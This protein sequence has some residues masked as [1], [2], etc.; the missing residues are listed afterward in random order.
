MPSPIGHALGAY[1]ALLALK[2]DLLADRRKNSLAVGAAFVLGSLADADFFV[3]HFAQGIYYLRHHYFS[4][5]IPFA[6]GFTFLCYLIL[7][8]IRARS[9]VKYSGLAGVAYGS[10]LLLDYFAQDG[11]AP[12]GIPLLWPIPPFHR[13]H[14]IAPIEIFFSIHR[15]EFTDLL[16]AHNLAAIAIEVAVLAPLCALAFV[17]AKRINAETQRLAGSK[18]SP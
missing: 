16:S 10:H 4:H 9:P 7:K 14:F 17:R 3:A 2:P 8:G 13:T 12:Y 15:G 18:G 6:L 11:S 1:A 5:S